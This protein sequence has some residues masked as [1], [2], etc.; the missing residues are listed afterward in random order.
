MRHNIASY[1]RKSLAMQVES[2]EQFKARTAESGFVDALVREWEP[3]ATTQTHVHPFDVDAVVV[4]GEMWLTCGDS[5]RHIANGDR[6]D[7]AH[8]IPHSERYGTEGATIWVAR[9]AAV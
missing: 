6:F 3:D 7:L 8:D 1:R 5:T 2:F 4:R 9:R